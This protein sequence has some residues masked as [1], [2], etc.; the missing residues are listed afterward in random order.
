L[1]Y[2]LPAMKD[3]LHVHHEA[4]GGTCIL[5]FKK[6]VGTTCYDFNLAPGHPYVVVHYRTMDHR[7]VLEI[8]QGPAVPTKKPTVRDDDPSDPTI[9]IPAPIQNIC[10]CED[11]TEF[12][13]PDDTVPDCSLPG[14]I[15]CVAPP[16]PIKPK[17]KS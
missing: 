4:S 5:R 7:C 8:Q 3:C 15:T 1:V 11:L 17:K 9:P 16:S 14:M 12:N 2:H 6:G 13:C 10:S